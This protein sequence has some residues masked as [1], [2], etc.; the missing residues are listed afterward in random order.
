[1]GRYSL[2]LIGMKLT[3]RM[4][5][6]WLAKVATARGS[7][8]VT[9][10]ACLFMKNAQAVDDL[11]KPIVV[12]SD[13]HFLTHPDGSPFFW[14][15]DSALTLFKYIT[16]VEADLYLRDRARKGF[17]VIQ[18][19]IAGYQGSANRAGAE[20]FSG[21]DPTQP[22]PLYFENVDWIVAKAADYGLRIAMLPMWGDLVTGSYAG[23][24]KIFTEANARIYGRWLGSRYRGKGIIWVLGGDTNALWPK[25]NFAT[26]FGEHNHRTDTT[27]ASNPIIDYRAIY[28]ALAAG[29]A[30]GQGGNPFFTYHPTQLAFLGTAPPRTSL[31]F[32]D[33][34]WL[35]MNMLQTGHFQNPVTSVFPQLKG[36]TFN[37]IGPLSYQP[38]GAEY[39]SRPTRPVIDGEPRWE[40][41][42]IDLR[43]GSSVRWT[44]YDSRQAAYQAVFAGAAGHNYGNHNVSSF[45]DPALRKPVE[46]EWRHWRESMNSPVSGQMRY[47]KELMLSRP[48]FSRIPDQSV[49]VGN[50]GEGSKHIGVT[51]DHQGAYVMAYLP[52]GESVTLDLAKLSGSSAIGWWYNPRTGK[53]SSIRGRFPTDRSH[54]FTPPAD[55]EERD[56]V[57][58]I[59][60]A[61]RS[62]A[63]PGRS[64]A[65][66]TFEP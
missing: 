1:M 61:S 66:E 8:A 42:S 52:D 34:D 22:N 10:V 26:Q 9:A 37:W 50:A 30:E 38:V 2:E 14:L 48:Y 60:D 36:V 5:C 4:R 3:H 43:K 44:G 6:T 15:G 56:W 57:L 29:I 55:E 47:L 18:A 49:I 16:R 12:S 33:R 45:Y 63:P 39:H 32:G 51:R 64:T 28:D 24:P 13:G 31:Y 62:F 7:I 41:I 11:T 46:L 40:E 54:R 59:D 35:D 53:A 25:D 17:T 58:V 65:P 23:G 20:P 21:N 27:A 19:V